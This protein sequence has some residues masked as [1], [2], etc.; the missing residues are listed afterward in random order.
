MHEF[1]RWLLELHACI[2]VTLYAALELARIADDALSG[3]GGV[4]LAHA[5]TYDRGDTP[6]Q[7]VALSKTST[8]TA[9]MTKQAKST[10]I[11]WRPNAGW[12]TAP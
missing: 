10:A 7:R 9:S 3:D 12:P 6:R 5:C 1:L 11:G 2:P 4:R 8:R